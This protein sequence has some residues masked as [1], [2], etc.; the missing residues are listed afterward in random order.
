MGKGFNAGL[1]NLEHQSWC[2]K[3]GY[4]VIVEP[5]GAFFSV[6]VYNGQIKHKYKEVKAKEL[7][8]EVWGLYT[9]IYNKNA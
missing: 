2:L 9:K 1:V 5:S 3:K 7:W 6:W 4:L 8:N